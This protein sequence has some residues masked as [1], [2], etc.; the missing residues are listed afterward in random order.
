MVVKLES[1][2]PST[3]VLVVVHLVAEVSA[4]AAAEDMAEE[5]VIHM[6]EAK[7]AAMAVDTVVAAMEELVGTVVIMVGHRVVSSRLEESWARDQ[8]ETDKSSGYGGGQQSRGG[9]Y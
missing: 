7:A 5:E 8:G 2:T 6:A 4:A 1:I 9:G 3:A